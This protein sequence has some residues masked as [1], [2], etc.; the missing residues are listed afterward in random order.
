MS[1]LNE[2]GQEV[3]D[4]TP[5]QL[6]FKFTRPVPLHIR[7]RNEILAVQES[8]RHQDEYDT[9]EDAD[10]F[11][12]E[13]EDWRSPYEVNFDHISIDENSNEKKSVSS[14]E[15]SNELSDGDTQPPQAGNEA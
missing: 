5:V 8:M 9:P 12:V 1:I 6:P 7:I 4:Q 14:K 2:F 13:D 15:S 3:F 10:D 11:D